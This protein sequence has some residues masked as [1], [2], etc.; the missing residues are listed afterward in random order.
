MNVLSTAELCAKNGEDGQVYVMCILPQ[1]GQK[2]R[3][4]K[5]IYLSK[6]KKKGSGLPWWHSG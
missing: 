1:L 3:N 5:L 4:Q 6:K 2:R